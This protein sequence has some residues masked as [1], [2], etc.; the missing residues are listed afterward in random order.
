MQCNHAQELF[1][2]YVAGDMDRALNVTLENH[3]S[4]CAECRDGVDG[5][6]SVWG[7]LDRLAVIDPPQQVHVNIMNSI[8]VVRAQ[9]EQAASQPVKTNWRSVFNPRSLALAASIL[10]A[11]FFATSHAM[12]AELDPIGTMIR[13]FRPAPAAVLG[14]SQPAADWSASAQGGV[15]TLHL[16]AQAN[17]AQV[18]HLNYQVMLG[19]RALPDVHGVVT[20]DQD[21]SV[22]IPL[23]AAPAQNALSV[24]LSPA[25]GGDQTKSIAVP[26]TGIP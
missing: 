6:R 24:T 10:L 25:D 5:L 16:R 17:G 15:I 8:A 3:L 12:R 19:G 9:E 4:E 26:V 2:D 18:N 20:S 11:L 7:A 23:N 1:S 13:M 14:L 22:V 21:T